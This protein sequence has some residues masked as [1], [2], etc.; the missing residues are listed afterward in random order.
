[1]QKSTAGRFHDARKTA[2]EA[3]TISTLQTVRELCQCGFR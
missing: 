2:L 1:M 3:Q